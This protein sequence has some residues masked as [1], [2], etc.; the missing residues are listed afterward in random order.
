M[1]MI[2]HQAL[3]ENVDAKAVQL[4]SHEIQLGPSIG[5]SLE[6]GKGMDRSLAVSRDADTQT[7]RLWKCAPCVKPSGAP[8]FQ[9]RI[10]GIVSP[11]FCPPST[12]APLPGGLT[13]KY[14]AA[15][16]VL[17]T[18]RTDARVISGGEAVIV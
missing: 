1:R 9:S 15:E 14:G 11:E 7:L 18:R 6:D 12:A 4:F 13:L 5:V 10:I 16:P 17:E 8:R 3:S 2:R